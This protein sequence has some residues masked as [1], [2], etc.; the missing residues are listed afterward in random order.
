MR[1]KAGRKKNNTVCAHH[2]DIRMLSLHDVFL[3]CHAELNAI[4]SAC[5]RGADPSSCILYVT[6]SPCNHCAQLVSQAE[7]PNSKVLF[8]R[9]YKPSPT[10]EDTTVQPEAAPGQE[11]TTVKPEAAPGQEDTTVKLEA[12]PGQEDTTVK[13]EAAP[14]Q[15]DTT[16]KPE[17]APGQEDTTVKPEA[18]PGQED[19][20]VKPEA[21]PG[22]EDTTVKPEAKIKLI[23][24]IIR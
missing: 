14:G 4:I 21:A 17:A 5:R 1:V 6:D 24:I 22:Q 16:V 19:T 9:N 20:T 12:A 15:E 13:P 10:K 7:I 18:A 3:V 11:D 2:M 8:S 23:H